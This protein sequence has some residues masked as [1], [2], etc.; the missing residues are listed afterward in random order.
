MELTEELQRKGYL[1]LMD[2]G[3]WLTGDLIGD[4]FDGEVVIDTYRGFTTSVQPYQASDRE[5]EGLN[6][7]SVDLH[8]SGFVIFN[9]LFTVFTNEPTDACFDDEDFLTAISMK[10][11]GYVSS[12]GRTH[13]MMTKAQ[14]SLNDFGNKHF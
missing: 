6:W 13:Q 4:E 12:D 11:L 5:F 9:K 8:E 14:K 7:Y 3:H 2:G 1:Y 10:S